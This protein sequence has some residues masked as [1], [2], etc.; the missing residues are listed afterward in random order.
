QRMDVVERRRNSRPGT[1]RVFD[2]L[3]NTL[4]E[5]AHYGRIERRGQLLEVEG[6]AASNRLVSALMRNLESSSHFTSAQLKRLYE[7]LRGDA[8]G[9]QGSSFEMTL[10]QVMPVAPDTLDGQG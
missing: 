10:L 8:Y 6:F 4:V 9:P 1:V 3:V 7:D 2:A 5:G